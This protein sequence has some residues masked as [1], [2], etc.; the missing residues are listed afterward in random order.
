MSKFEILVSRGNL[1][2]HNTTIQIE[3]ATKEEAQSK[4]LEMAENF[5]EEKWEEVGMADYNFQEEETKEI[6]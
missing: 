3:A 1:V 2:V 5:G 4:A 6:E